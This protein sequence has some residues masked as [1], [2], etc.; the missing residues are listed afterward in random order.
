MSESRAL[1][2]AV[3]SFLFFAAIVVALFIVADVDNMVL[4]IGPLLVVAIA[5]VGVY[6]AAR[7]DRG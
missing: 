6:K 4:I 7:D 3:G 1:L 5:C 2:M